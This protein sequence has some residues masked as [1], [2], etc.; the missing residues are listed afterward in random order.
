MVGAADVI[1]DFVPLIQR[2]FTQTIAGRSV[3]DDQIQSVMLYEYDPL[4]NSYN[5]RGSIPV[6]SRIAA[7]S[8]VN[9]FV[10]IM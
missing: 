9:G 4:T 5:R 8:A 3:Y 10:G 1:G 7:A 2:W 6:S